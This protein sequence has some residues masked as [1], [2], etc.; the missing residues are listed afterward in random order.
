MTV[1]TFNICEN[2]HIYFKV[3]SFD[4]TNAPPGR[5]SRRGV[6]LFAGLTYSEEPPQQRRQQGR[7]PDYHYFH[8]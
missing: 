6:A 7:G 3:F 4:T 5:K 8:D 2:S 1:K